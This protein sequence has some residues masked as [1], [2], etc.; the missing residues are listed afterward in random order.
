V[1]QHSS[2]HRFTI[3]NTF[4]LLKNHEHTLNVRIRYYQ[5]NRDETDLTTLGVQNSKL[6]PFLEQRKKSNN[7]LIINKSLHKE[8]ELESQSWSQSQ[9][10]SRLLSYCHLNM[11]YSEEQWYTGSRFH[12]QLMM[13][14]SKLM[15]PSKILCLSP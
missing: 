2:L 3:K 10:G 5:N 11:E 14:C 4:K 15:R 1:A 9:R 13:R 7:K 8:N 12:R 6:Q